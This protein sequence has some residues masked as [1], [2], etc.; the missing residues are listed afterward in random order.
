MPLYKLRIHG[1]VQGVFYRYSTKQQAE[2]LG[3]TGMV[4]NEMDGSVYAEIEGEETALRQMIEWCREGPERAVVQEVVVH[5]GP[6]KGYTSF[7]IVR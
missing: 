2:S 5:A 1:R 7:E 3:I 4:K 6:P